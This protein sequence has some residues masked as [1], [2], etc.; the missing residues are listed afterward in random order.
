MATV[1]FD[2]IYVATYDKQE[3]FE[4]EFPI[5]AT[6]GGAVSAKITGVGATTN[7]VFASDVPFYVAAKGTSSPKAEL[8]IA[9]LY[10]ECYDAITGADVTEDGFTILGS[11]TMPPYA[12]I[13]CVTH[14]KEGN[15]LFIGMP[16]GKFSA[17]DDELK[18]GEDKGVELQTDT[19]EGNF[20][21]AVRGGK[22][23]AYIKGSTKDPNM[24]LEK[25]KAFVFDTDKVTTT[26]TTKATTTTTTVKPTTTTTAATTT[27]TT[28][29]G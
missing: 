2:A 28:V 8:G 17:P 19:I 27:T 4:Q 25:F 16:K 13:V 22:N 18:S 14:D 5:D 20:V 3:K 7:T 23:A 21:N 24:T 6:Q 26:T 1:G 9:D 29:E 12:G 11:D 10:S 15:Q